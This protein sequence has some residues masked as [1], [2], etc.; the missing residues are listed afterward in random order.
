MLYLKLHMLG[1]WAP[2]IQMARM[3]G[4]LYMFRKLLRFV[5]SS[6]SLFNQSIVCTCICLTALFYLPRFKITPLFHVVS[7][8]LR[9]RLLSL[10]S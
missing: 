5:L 3:S 4:V 2:W 8:E 6:F 9:A 10:I 7:S 1:G